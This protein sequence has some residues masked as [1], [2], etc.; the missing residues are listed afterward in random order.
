M[1]PNLE[2]LRNLMKKLK[3]EWPTIKNSI[4]G[5]INGRVFEL[6]N[7]R[8]MKIIANNAPQEWK[9]LLRLQGTHVVPR[10]N[11]KNHLTIRLR[12]KD[13]EEVK[14]MLSMYTIGNKLTVMIMGRVGSGGQTMT[15]RQYYRKFRPKNIKPLQKRVHELID[16]MH[17]RGVSHGNLHGGNIIVTVNS[18][19]HIAGMW[20]IDFGRS[21]TF[22]IGTTESNF[23]GRFKP[24]NHE[25]VTTITGITGC[26]VPVYAGSRPNTKMSQ[27]LY[28]KIYPKDREKRMMNRRL[29]IAENLKLLKSPRKV[30]TVRR[31]QSANR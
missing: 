22:P 15:L 10:F 29:N 21:R 6:N 7:G 2:K 5:G 3:P 8:Y 12:P 28:C 25:P 17:V 18:K 13:K 26:N 4:G 11:K 16:E 27:V 23:Y 9:T 30:S 20:V 14:N 1:P 31:V 19:G 24:G